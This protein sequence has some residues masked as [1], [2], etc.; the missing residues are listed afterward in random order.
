MITGF[1]QKWSTVTIVADRLR[2]YLDHDNTDIN[3]ADQIV[4][5]VTDN[6]LFATFYNMITKLLYYNLY[7]EE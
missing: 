6:V 2:Y 1:S 3:P 7:V 5:K 4:Y